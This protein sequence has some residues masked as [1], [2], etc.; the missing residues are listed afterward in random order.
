M[1]LLDQFAVRQIEFIKTGVDKNSA[2]VYCRTHGSI[3][4]K[5]GRGHSGNK[6]N[7]FAILC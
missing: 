1:D 2:I 6:I 4:N 3:E 7:Q 5:R